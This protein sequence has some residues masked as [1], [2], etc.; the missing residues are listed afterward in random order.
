MV[1]PARRSHITGNHRV[2]AILSS[3]ASA[4]DRTYR[5]GTAK[6]YSSD[7]RPD[8]GAEW[9]IRPAD[10]IS[11]AITGFRRSCPARRVRQIG[12]TV[13]ERRNST[14]PT[15]GRIAGLNG[16]S[17]PPIAYHRQSPGSGDPVQL[18][19]CVRSDVPYRN[20]ETLLFR[21]QAG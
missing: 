7:N 18:G 12:R 5:I 2:P 8:S 3:S 10:R 17:G 19:E 13:S 21:Q 14:L 1:H 11:P 16:P 6:L 4:S 20:G 15:T 9:S